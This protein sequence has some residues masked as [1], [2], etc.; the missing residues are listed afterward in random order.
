MLQR[1]VLFPLVENKIPI[2]LNSTKKR[3]WF[4]LG[5]Y[6][7]FIFVC[8]GLCFWKHSAVYVIKSNVKDKRKMGLGNP[9]N[10]GKLITSIYLPTEGLRPR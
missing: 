4:L 6:L 10:R 2:S 3:L 5:A 8:L 1:Y 9:E 7:F